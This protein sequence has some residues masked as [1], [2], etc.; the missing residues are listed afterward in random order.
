[1]S[2]D[3]LSIEAQEACR[4]IVQA[5][6]RG[7]PLI[8]CIAG[9]GQ[10]TAM[11]GATTR[12]SVS[13]DMGIRRELEAAGYLDE[14]RIMDGGHSEYRVTSKAFN[15]VEV[16]FVPQGYV[17]LD[18]H[19]TDREAL[20]LL[21]RISREHGELLDFHVSRTSGGEVLMLLR[22]GQ[23]FNGGKSDRI[24]I[25]AVE[26]MAELG[27]V[28]ANPSAKGSIRGRIR[29][30]AFD[31]VD[32]GFHVPPDS[33][34]DDKP[35]SNS[36]TVM[37]NLG[38]LNQGSGTQNIATINQVQVAAAQPELQSLVDGVDELPAAI[39]EDVR[40]SVND[41]REELESDQPR[42]SRVRAFLQS[43]WLR[44]REVAAFSSHV[45]ALA[46]RLGLKI[47]DLAG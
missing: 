15:E 9:F 36:V 22:E 44:T 46:E 40:E 27:L 30:R 43:T 6:D 37:G 32:N 5:V 39:R 13:V 45:T 7:R 3:G 25:G 11:V 26:A 31:A 4:Q 28:S 18:L 41:I 23:S 14:I 34:R 2:R 47:D 16:G 38:A 42:R 12:R 24:S 20:A 19:V 21:I 35:A 33:V 10:P 29:Q 8:R 1:M 17:P